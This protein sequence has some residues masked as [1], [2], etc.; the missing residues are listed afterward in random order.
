GRQSRRPSRRR[1]LHGPRNC[2]SRLW[3]RGRTTVVGKAH[4]A[5]GALVCVRRHG[6]LAYGAFVLGRGSFGEFGSA[7]R[8]DGGV[9]GD[10]GL[11]QRAHPSVRLDG[12]IADGTDLRFFRWR[13]PTPR[14][15]DVFSIFEQ[16][17]KTFGTQ[18]RE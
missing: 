13:K 3:G 15:V 10:E 14:L 12:R 17:T 11:A 6:R 5:V 16:R 9:C 4:S 8:A 7:S 18:S 1:H 2:R